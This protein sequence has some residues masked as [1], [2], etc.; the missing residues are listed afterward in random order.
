MLSF[1]RVAVAVVS[2]HR[3]EILTMTTTPNLLEE[4]DFKD[5]IFSLNLQEGPKISEATREAHTDEALGV[6]AYPIK[7]AVLL[8]LYTDSVNGRFGGTD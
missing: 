2:L 7:A 6:M 1:E 5:K 3:T 4:E 8:W